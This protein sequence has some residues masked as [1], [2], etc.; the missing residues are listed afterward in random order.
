VISLS[1][2]TQGQITP[3]RQ[4]LFLV[5]LGMLAFSVASEPGD[6]T[7]LL[8]DTGRTTTVLA[9]SYASMLQEQP[10][11][12]LVAPSDRSVIIGSSRTSYL[13]H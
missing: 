7:I 4:T 1:L 12:I 2:I 5:T 10:R 6:R 3:S 9:V 8:S 11:K 13:Q